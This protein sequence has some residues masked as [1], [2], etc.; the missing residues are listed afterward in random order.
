MPFQVPHAGG[1]EP[2]AKEKNF[3]TQKLVVVSNES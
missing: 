2:Q 1:G 3:E